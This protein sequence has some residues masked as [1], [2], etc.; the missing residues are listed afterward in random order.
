[1]KNEITFLIQARLASTRLPAKVLKTLYSMSL[2]EGVYHRIRHENVFILTSTSSSDDDLYQFCLDKGLAVHRG[3]ENNVFSRFYDVIKDL[4]TP[5]VARIT[6]DNPF[7]ETDNCQKM[8]QRMKDEDLDRILNVYLPLGSSFEILTKQS[9]LKQAQEEMNDFQKEHV[10]SAYYQNPDL[11]KCGVFK[12]NFKHLSHLRLTIDE[13]LDLGLIK[14][15]CQF[16]Q[17]DSHEISMQEIEELYQK[18]PR[19]FL[20]NQKVQQR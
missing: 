16:Y 9:F 14:K 2:I 15:I 4:K 11:Y 6:G 5:Y 1:M 13:V 20:M 3:S 8:I 17:K 7:V 18:N 19:L 12:E 10:T